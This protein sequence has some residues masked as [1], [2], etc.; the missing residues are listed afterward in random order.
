[1]ANWKKVIVSGSSAQL[2]QLSVDTSVSITGSLAASSSVFFP[3]LTD[4]PQP[5][6]IGYDVTSGRLYSQGTGSFTANSASYAL[7]ASYVNPLNQTVEIAGG[8]NVTGSTTLSGS[9]GVTG[10]NSITGSLS[11]DGTTTITGSLSVAASAQIS[12]SLNVTGSTTL[13][14]SLGVTGSQNITGSLSVD[15]A[16]TITGSLSIAS[17]AQISGS[18]GVTGSTAFTGSLGVT[19]STSLT[20]SLDIAGATTIT[21][22]L[23]IGADTQISG[24]LGVTGSTVFTGSVGITGSLNVT[25][26]LIATEANITGSFTGSFFGDGGGLTNIPASGIVGLNLS[27]IASGSAT[28]SISPDGGLQVNTNTTITGSLT[29]SGSVG[30][31]FDINADTFIFTGSLSTTGSVSFNGLTNV[32]Q[33]TIVSIDA[34]TGQ[35]FYQGTGSF[36]ANSASYAVSASYANE[37]G[38]VTNTLAQGTGINVFSY[39]G[40]LAAAVSV[41]GASNLI[42][43]N[44]TKWT[45]TAFGTSSITDSTNVTINNAGGVLVQTGGLYVTGSSIF[46][47]SVTIQGNLTVAGTAS[48]QHS[49]NLAIADQFILLNSGSTTFEDSGFIIS[50]GNT[51]NSGSAFFLETAGTTTG[52]DSLNGRFAVAGNVQPNAT[53]VTA[54]EYA[55]TTVISGSIPTT[56]VPQFGGTNLGQGNMWVD[57][58]TGDIYIY[59]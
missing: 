11:I 5:H 22:S 43:N 19:G 1:M 3:A 36:T 49:D 54:Q 6:I 4:V 59:S 58:N 2:S 53:T 14:G 25:G 10:S 48:F 39:D 56:N 38:K 17:A 31:S 16:T 44:V 8:L 41:A 18:L 12:G 7:T 27:Q 51:G 42:T 20:G 47:D 9:L 15:G 45:G 24:S 13:S 28:A 37:A 50:T 40:S 57:S 26:S 33:A 32:P 34:A 46:H 52:T 35:L 23:S 30:S 21:G 29:V 55:V